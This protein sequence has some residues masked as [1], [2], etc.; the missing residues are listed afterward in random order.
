M[1][2][3]TRKLII[4]TAQWGI[5]YGISNNEGKTDYGEVKKI[6]ELAEQN[7]IS[8]LDTAKA[9]GDSEKVIGNLKSN[10]TEVITKVIIGNQDRDA[11][12]IKTMIR[13]S[14]YESYEIMGRTPL[15]G[16]LVHDPKNM[17]SNEEN[18]GW[19]TLRSMKE[20]GY[21][22]RLGLS[23]EDP[24]EAIELSKLYIPDIIQMPM[25]VF[26]QRATKS[27]ALEGLKKRG[28]EIHI[29]SVFLQ[30]LLLM[31]PKDID[32]Y[33]KP[34][35][36]NIANWQEYCQN[37]NRTRIEG[38]LLPIIRE[39]LIDK[40]IVGI[41]SSQQLKEIL[42]ALENLGETKSVEDFSIDDNKLI[43]PSRWEIAK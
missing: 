43:N 6:L 7:N 27:G 30:G 2:D 25:N 9:Y 28:I 17:R 18:T 16:V 23:I 38:A 40:F 31:N 5:D 10:E 22:E 36:N 26:D 20:E 33:F 24:N 32:N 34:W 8:A 13:A 29:R 41:A 39:E 3:N 21:I 37:E 12:Q 11:R 4:G 14:V 35:I 1:T 42:K 15:R 19:E